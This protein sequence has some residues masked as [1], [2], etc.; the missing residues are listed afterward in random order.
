MNGCINNLIIIFGKEE[1]MMQ[2]QRLFLRT[3]CL[4][5]AFFLVILWNIR[6]A[7][8]QNKLDHS[9]FMWLAE[10]RNE[11]GNA[12]GSLRPS[13]EHTPFK[14]KSENAALRWSL[15]STV[16][17][18]TVGATIWILDKHQ[19][20]YY[21]H[22]TYTDIEEH[23]PSRLIPVT[24]IFSGIIFGP[25]MGYFYAGESWRGIKGMIV[26]LVLGGGTG[27]CFLVAVGIGEENYANSTSPYGEIA[28]VGGV[29]LLADAIYDIAKVKSTVQKH[30]SRLQKTSL[31]LAPKYFADSKACGIRVQIRF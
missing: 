15:L 27:L 8:A 25:S 10:N 18:I 12:L 6:P 30:N 9:L 22:G 26:R 14:L 20:K 4:L 7:I 5:F 11:E 16:V 17:P 28:F 24:L 13:Q 19:V 31:I 29:A 21:T 1:W 2:A 3:S 23:Q